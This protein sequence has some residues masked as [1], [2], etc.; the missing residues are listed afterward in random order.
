MLTLL[1][2]YSK[3]DIIASAYSTPRKSYIQIRLHN[4]RP[5][6]ASVKALFTTIP[7]EAPNISKS[8]I[9]YIPGTSMRTG[10]RKID[11]DTGIVFLEDLIASIDDPTY[12]IPVPP[13]LTNY[14]RVLHTKQ[15]TIAPDQDLE[16]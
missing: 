7:P 8:I 3:E 5:H 13:T 9:D 1:K 2:D 12:T 6:L 10:N 15:G 14:T 4:T 11:M 16:L